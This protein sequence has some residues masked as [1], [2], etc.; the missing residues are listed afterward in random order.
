MRPK[1]QDFY[2]TLDV[3]WEKVKVLSTYLN[4]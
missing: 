2:V 4:A 3:E 1:S